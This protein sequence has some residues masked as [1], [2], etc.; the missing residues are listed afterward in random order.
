MAAR[1]ATVE[2]GQERMLT[3]SLSSSARGAK[4]S[5]QSW[6]SG[7]VKQFREGRGRHRHHLAGKAGMQ[8]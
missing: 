7:C 4:A 1:K 6:G 3:A 2:W 8:S 5:G